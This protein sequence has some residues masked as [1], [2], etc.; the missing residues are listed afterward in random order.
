L[1]PFHQY[2]NTRCSP[3]HASRHIIRMWQSRTSISPHVDRPLNH[4]CPNERPRLILRHSLT[5]PTSLVP[6]SIS[7]PSIRNTLDRIAQT[8]YVAQTQRAAAPRVRHVAAQPNRTKSY[9][10]VPKDRAALQHGTSGPNVSWANTS[11]D[12]P[13]S[14]VC[15]CLETWR[16]RSVVRSVPWRGVS[17]EGEKHVG[18]WADVMEDAW[19]V[20]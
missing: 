19:L 2:H 20:L 17:W 15:A 4:T 6:E 14:I 9:Q 16:I 18:C 11:S 7:Q 3:H 12:I 5:P 1:W 10:I 8:K 13:P